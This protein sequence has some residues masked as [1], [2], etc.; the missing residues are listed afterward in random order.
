MSTGGSIL[1]SA[2]EVFVFDAV[3]AQLQG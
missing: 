1:A 2:E 3:L